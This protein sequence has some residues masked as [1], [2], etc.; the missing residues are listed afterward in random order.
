MKKSGKTNRAELSDR[1][2]VQNFRDCAKLFAEEGWLVFFE[3]IEAYH[4]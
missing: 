1:S 3:K 4:S 2:W